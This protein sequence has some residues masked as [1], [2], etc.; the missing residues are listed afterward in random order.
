MISSPE[1][2]QELQRRVENLRTVLH[3]NIVFESGRFGVYKLNTNSP[4]SVSHAIS[5]GTDDLSKIARVAEESEYLNNIQLGPFLDDDSLIVLSDLL[6]PESSGGAITIV[7]PTSEHHMP[8]RYW[9]TGAIN[10]GWLSTIMP[11]LNNFGIKTWQFDYNK[12]FIFTWG[13][14]YIPSNYTLENA[15]TLTTFD[16]NSPDEISQWQSNQPKIQA[17]EHE[18]N[19]MR[20]VLN[21][22]NSGWKTI[23]SP[24][25]HVSADRVYVGKLGIQIRQCRRRALKTNRVRQE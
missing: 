8:G 22:S 23:T 19:A 14:E 24:A 9:S 18:S 10:G 25:F 3:E 21:S 20:V 11:Y 4:V 17:L 1:P 2:L 13:E 6:P 12:G 16:F 5:A 15:K 7:D